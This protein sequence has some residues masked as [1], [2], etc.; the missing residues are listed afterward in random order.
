VPLEGSASYSEISERLSLPQD[1][2]TRAIQHATTLRLFEEVGDDSSRIRHT[3][4]SAAL[5]RQPGLQALVSSVLDV[6]G[7]PMM[8]M[9]S[10]LEKYSRGKSELTQDMSE[11]AFALFHSTGPLGKKHV[12]S[13]DY[14]END[15]EGERQGW[16]QQ[17][18]VD[19]MK[20]IKEIFQLDGI[21]LNAYD[22]EAAGSATVVDVSSID[23]RRGMGKGRRRLTPRC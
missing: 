15:G 9:P 21:V 4:R 10:A 22:W 17:K 19:F 11:T 8:T 5:A 13:W 16:R 7:A 1:V 20:Y 12:N 23:R 18:F 3:S 2:V 6:T 14:L